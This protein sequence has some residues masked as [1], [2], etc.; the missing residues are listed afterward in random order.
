MRPDDPGSAGSDLD[1]GAELPFDADLE[2]LDAEFAAAGAHARRMLSGRTQPTRL[3]TNQLRSRLLAAF[4]PASTAADH[5]ELSL[6]RAPAR[7]R[8]ERQGSIAQR[9]PEQEET[10]AVGPNG[11]RAAGPAGPITL[12]AALATLSIVGMIGLLAMVALAGSAGS[13]LP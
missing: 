8:R 3:F 11:G 13:P 10:P 7:D 12:R 4:E 2:S 6:R 9:G 5:G 1:P